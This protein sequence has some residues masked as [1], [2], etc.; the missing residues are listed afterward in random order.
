MRQELSQSQQDV[1]SLQS[2]LDQVQ[3][4]SQQAAAQAE[5]TYKETQIAAA[6]DA[7]LKLS[8][9]Q[10]Q[11]TQLMTELDAVRQQLLQSQYS[12]AQRP[13]EQSSKDISVDSLL[14]ASPFDLGTDAPTVAPP[15]TAS[16][17]A[18]GNISLGHLDPV[19]NRF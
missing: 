4:E 12:A 8:V 9:S 7:S 5:S 19:I 2:H 17:D 11:V 15:T 14:T 3:A 1:S 13:E 18:Q 10:Q 6:A 16:L